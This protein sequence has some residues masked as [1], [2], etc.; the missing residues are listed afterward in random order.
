MSI[1]APIE[2]LRET[3]TELRRLRERLKELED[4]NTQEPEPEPIER[5]MVVV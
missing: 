3:R 2:Q 1:H 4:K 5:E